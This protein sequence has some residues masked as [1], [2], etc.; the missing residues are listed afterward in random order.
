[1]AKSIDFTPASLAARWGVHPGTLA[2]WRVRN[3]GPPYRK[4]GKARTSKVLYLRRDTI[5]WGKA[6]GYET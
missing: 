3:D 6:Y 2:N 1:M 5:R 4:K